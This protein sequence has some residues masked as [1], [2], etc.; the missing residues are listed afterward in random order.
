MR[1]SRLSESRRPVAVAVGLAGLLLWGLGGFAWSA[2]TEPGNADSGRALFHGKGA[3]AMCHGVEGDQRNRP[4]M[5]KETAEVIRKLAPPP[6]DLRLPDHRRLL[7]DQQRFKAIRKGH[8]GTAMLPDPTL[9]D[10]EITDILAYLERL[11][12]TNL[13]TP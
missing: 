10:Q 7:S 4:P 3:C 5:R 2:Q 6:A 9:S 1:D 11:R 13:P 8:P 12:Q